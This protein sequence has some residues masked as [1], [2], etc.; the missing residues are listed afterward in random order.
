MSEP[1]SKNMSYIIKQTAL[2][3]GVDMKEGIYCAVSGPS[4]ETPAEVRMLG[5]LGADAVGMSTVPE[6]I[7]ARHS[8]I[9]VAGISFISN[10]AAGLSHEEL[11]HEEVTR[12][13]RM[14]E[15]DFARLLN[16]VTERFL[17]EA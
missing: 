10:K 17:R 9:E 1:Y 16:A 7:V 14:V 6:V 8:G 13:A 15:E 12:N 4:F 3:L 2:S 11:T 5:T